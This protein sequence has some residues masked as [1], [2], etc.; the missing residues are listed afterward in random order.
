LSTKIHG[1]TALTDDVRSKALLVEMHDEILKF[2]IF[3][4]FTTFLKNSQPFI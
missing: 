1:N 4:N 2:K 3:T